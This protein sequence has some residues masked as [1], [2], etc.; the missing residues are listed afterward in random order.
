MQVLRNS[1]RTGPVG[2]S[3]GSAVSSAEATFIRRTLL[4]LIF[5]PPEQS[6]SVDGLEQRLR[7]A[8][9]LLEKAQVTT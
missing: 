3:K 8:L 4:D 1:N 2:R 7:A 6:K 9:R 5:K